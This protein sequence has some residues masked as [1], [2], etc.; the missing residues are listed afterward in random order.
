MLKSVKRSIATVAGCSLLLVMGSLALAAPASAGGRPVN[1]AFVQAW[2]KVYLHQQGAKL[3]VTAELRCVPGWFPVE[4]DM[5]VN[6][7][8]QATSNYTIPTIPCDND[9]HAVRFAI[10]G[11]TPPMHVGAATISSQF[12]VNNVDSGDSAAGHDP[13]RPGC[14]MRPHHP[15]PCRGLL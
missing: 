11:V 4:L 3:T 7:D 14:I 13:Q 6:Q 1:V 2:K 9:W 8:S 5:Q 12:I 15:K 10:E